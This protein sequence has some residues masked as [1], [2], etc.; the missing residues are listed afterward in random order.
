M[1]C[2][3]TTFAPQLLMNEAKSRLVNRE[4]LKILFR[5][6][7]KHIKQKAA[8]R[9]LEAIEKEQHHLSN[10]AIFSKTSCSLHIL[11]ELDLI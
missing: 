5:K 7:V 11:R 8:L 3:D 6:P 2:I 10:K 9:S 1:H 4:N